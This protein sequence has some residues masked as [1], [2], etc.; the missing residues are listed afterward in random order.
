MAGAVTTAWS[1]NGPA[2]PPNI[3][4]ILSD[5]EGYA[6]LGCFGGEAIQAPN[7][8]RLASQGAH[9]TSFYLA[10]PACAPSRAAL[11]SGR[12]PQRNGALR[13]DP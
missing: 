13:H 11:L 4:I 2:A 5:D 12:Y 8:D 1:A 3:I 6:D 9:L 10:W 7:L